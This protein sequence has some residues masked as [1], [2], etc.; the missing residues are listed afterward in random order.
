MSVVIIGLSA[1]Q[2][3]YKRDDR[4]LLGTV[5]TSLALVANN[6]SDIDIVTYPSGESKRILGPEAVK[7]LA[8]GVCEVA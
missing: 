4:I 5:K 2:D 1:F 8:R 3:V 6:L 7:G